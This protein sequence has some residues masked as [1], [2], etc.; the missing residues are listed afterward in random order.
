MVCVEFTQFK[1]KLCYFILKFDDLFF[2]LLIVKFERSDLT[3]VILFE[4]YG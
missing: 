1:F 2:L 3:V 4:L